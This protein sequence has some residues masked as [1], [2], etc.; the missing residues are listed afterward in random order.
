MLDIEREG[1]GNFY[2]ARRRARNLGLIGTPA[3]D[4]YP[5]HCAKAAIDTRCC[6]EPFPAAGNYVRFS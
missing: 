1:Y 3:A 5:N 2:Q 4:S 6:E